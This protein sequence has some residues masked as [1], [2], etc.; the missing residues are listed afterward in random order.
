MCIVKRRTTA[1]IRSLHYPAELISVYGSATF[2]ILIT[3]ALLQEQKKNDADDE[4]EDGEDEEMWTPSKR[5]RVNI[6]RDA[7]N[8]PLRADRS[9][10]CKYWA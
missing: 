1:L 8:L 5:R 3:L 4:E 2:L 6:L 7:R 10:N 9:E